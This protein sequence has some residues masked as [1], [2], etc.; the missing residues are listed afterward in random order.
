MKILSNWEEVGS[1]VNGLKKE[2][3]P[4]HTDPAKC[5]DLFNIRDMLLRNNVAS[6]ACIV[7]MGCGASVYGSVTL[8][9]LRAMGFQNLIGIDLYIPLYARLGALLRGWGKFRELIP[10]QMIAGDMTSTKFANNSVDVA[11]S[12]SVIEHGVDLDKLFY[13]L[14]RVVKV[15][16]VV[17]VSTDYWEQKI[18]LSSGMAASGARD[19][20][21]LPWTIFDL[22]SLNGVIAIANK[23]GFLEVGD[24]VIPPCQDKPIYWQGADYTFIAM[25][26]KKS[27]VA[28]AVFRK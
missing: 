12:L 27:G 13:E 22:T 6:D 15:G 8:E 5:W 23:Y 4:L 28:N 9:F 10:Y 21:S 16:G 7:D 17:Y 18:E 14:S 19:N 20:Q 11:I 24:K 1:A 3:L 25:E 2:E 26:F